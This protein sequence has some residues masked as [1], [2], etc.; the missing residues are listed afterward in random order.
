[1][2]SHHSFT[3]QEEVAR[4]GRGLLD[5]TLPKAEWTHAG[6]FAATLWVLACRPDLEAARD[7]P[8]HIRAYNQATGV[9]NTPTAGYHETITQA[10]IAAAQDFLTKHKEAELHVIC[11]ELLQTV[12]GDPN[13]LGEY[14][15]QTTLF[16]VEARR[17]WCPPDRKSLP[18]K[19]KPEAT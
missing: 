1:M 17:Q 9:E 18:F 12:L 3:S 13:W 2:H 8:G 14:W 6:H 19:T 5:C 4:I 11:N 15:T 10:S 16:S 7:L